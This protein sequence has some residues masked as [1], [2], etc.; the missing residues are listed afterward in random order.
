[1]KYIASSALCIAW[2]DVDLFV[3]CLPLVSQVYYKL[4]YEIHRIASKNTIFS[5]T[6]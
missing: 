6:S 5:G 4:H 3:E 2:M 1:M